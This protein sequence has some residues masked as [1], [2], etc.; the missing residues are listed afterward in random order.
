MSFKE[1]FKFIWQYARPYKM[2]LLMFSIM[3]LAITISQLTTPYLLGKITDVAIGRSNFF[4][5]LWWHIAIITMVILMFVRLGE[6]LL[7]WLMA[8]QNDRIQR[9]FAIDMC[10]NG[11]NLSVGYY[12]TQKPG[13]TLKIISRSNDSMSMA[14]NMIVLDFMPGILGMIGS[15]I[16]FFFLNQTIGAVMLATVIIYFLL[17]FYYK[18]PEILKQQDH[19][20]QL[21][22]DV[23]GKIGDMLANFFAVKTCVTED[24]EVEAR[25]KE[26]K[27]IIPL[28]FKLNRYW[29]SYNLAQGFVMV[30]CR[31]SI[32]ITL[33]YLLK[34]QMITEGD[35][36]A[37]IIYIGYV[38]GPLNMI[39]NN[40]RRL[41]TSLVDVQ[42]S[43]KL[44]EEVRENDLPEAK[45]VNLH[46][47]IEFTNVSFAYNGDD[48][49]ILNNVNLVIHS[50]K[51]VAIMGQTGVGKSTLT[52]LIL[53]LFEP[54]QGQ[55]LFD[56]IDSRQIK[57]SSLRSQIAVVPQD[58]VLFHD[59]L[60]ENIRYGKPHA[61]MEEVIAAAKIANAHDFIMDK[62]D[63]Y[64]SVVGER[65]VML[66]G[67]Q[68][69]RIAIARA[70]LRDPKILILDEA[71]KDLDIETKDEVLAALQNV[72]SGRTVIVITHDF[73]SITRS[74]DNIVVLDQGQI[75]QQG[76]H[77]KLLKE[78]G[79]Y[80][81][82]WQK[83]M[84][85]LGIA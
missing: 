74:A 24:F 46:G 43:M 32:I 63:G 84:Q 9:D 65:G 80:K 49:G 8:N 2:R 35:L 42:D 58:P 67:G 10:K 57:R 81:N 54:K 62:P 64:D 16:W 29:F 82:Y 20:N 40:I 33:I 3:M 77:E 12:H 44:K 73:S 6:S 60:L 61:T 68:R 71:T 79:I 83:L 55:I 7:R 53:R 50:G 31:I 47:E 30:V 23:Y 41:R 76:K 69:Q 70:A 15:L 37:F 5:L 21:F 72:I 27:T 39:N 13:S 22:N 25:K 18:M 11:V 52:N 36:L 4:N 78:K 28:T 34:S 59:S 17:S 14:I 45:E 26:F 38:L 1:K 48:E 66:S 56:G 75:A 19:N 85:T 51:M